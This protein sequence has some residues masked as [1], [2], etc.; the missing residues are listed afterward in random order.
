LR[1]IGHLLRHLGVAVGRIHELRAK[2]H[3]DH[4]APS[5][6]WNPDTDNCKGFDRWG[7]AV[8]S[9]SR[10]RQSQSAVAVDDSFLPTE[11]ETADCDGYWP[12]APDMMLMPWRTVARSRPSAPTRMPRTSYAPG[13]RLRNS[14][15]VVCG[16]R[17]PSSVTSLLR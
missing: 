7:Q 17:S 9:L 16:A 1:E 8:G 15:S 5:R 2:Q 3:D 12:A 10:S 4:S 13:G 6:C 14:N 11:T